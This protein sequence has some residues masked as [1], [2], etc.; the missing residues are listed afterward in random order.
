MEIPDLYANSIFVAAR[1]VGRRAA[2][3]QPRPFFSERNR[4][5]ASLS[6]TNGYSCG[7]NVISSISRERDYYL[8][9]YI[10]RRDCKD[11]LFSPVISFTPSI[12]IAYLTNCKKRIAIVYVI[13][14]RNV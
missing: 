1:D 13:L 14:F 11:A 10:M 7:R 5:G 4:E 3:R 6:D 12:S 8:Y 2:S 9:I